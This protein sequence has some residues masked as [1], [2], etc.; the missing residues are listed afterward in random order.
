MNYVLKFY[1]S[2]NSPVSKD[3]LLSFLKYQTEPV[4]N[5]EETFSYK[6]KETGVYCTFSFE[7]EKQ[8]NANWIY[9]GLSFSIRLLVPDFFGKESFQLIGS[10]F[11]QF[12]LYVQ[13]EHSDV[14]P[15]LCTTNELYSNWKAKNHQL[16]MDKFSKNGLLYASP[17]KTNYAWQY[18]L[19]RK[20][21]KKKMG[22]EFHIPSIQY[23]H[24][25]SSMEVDTYTVWPDFIPC[26]LPKVDFIVLKQRPR[27]F[28]IGQANSLLIRYETLI[29]LIGDRFEQKDE[30]LILDPDAAFLLKKTNP[31]FESMATL[32]EYGWMIQAEDFVNVKSNKLETST[33]N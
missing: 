29:H 11:A 10:L 26:V 6:N 24:N 20:K 12:D 1:T 28:F 15:R 4:E 19:D 2:T 9:T 25:K 18:A 32:D 7:P 17:E 27:K 30:E 13:E 3:K 16:A 22:G 8:E 21:L 23:I 5:V 33:T 14:Q 31:S